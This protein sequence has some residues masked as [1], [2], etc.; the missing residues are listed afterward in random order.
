LFRT[1]KFALDRSRPPIA[2]HVVPVSNESLPSGHATMSTVVIGTIVVLAWAGRTMVERT[3]MVAAAAL[4]VGAVGATRVY[5]GVHWLS[6]VLAGWAVGAAWLT[7]CVLVW[8][9]WRTR[10]RRSTLLG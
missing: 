5:L 10:E 7:V 3:V 9:R 8:S 2:D 6:D 4:W 1:L